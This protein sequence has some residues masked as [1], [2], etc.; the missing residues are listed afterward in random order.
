[1]PSYPIMDF[2]NWCILFTV[3]VQLIVI[4][5]WR[6]Q[7]IKPLKVLLYMVSHDFIPSKQVSLMMY[8]RIWTSHT[9]T[10]SRLHMYTEQ[11]AHVHRASCTCTQGSL[12]MYTEQAAHVHR[13]GCRKSIV[14]IQTIASLWST[15]G[16]FKT[17]IPSANGV[18]PKL[19]YT[20]WFPCSE[21]CILMGTHQ[22]CC[23]T[24][25][26]GIFLNP[27]HFQDGCNL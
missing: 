26:A 15:W 16:A 6:Y 23:C 4:Q 17:P 25:A 7:N 12:H 13:A 19:T 21:L 2:K 10:Q 3:V 22:I 20:T 11:A 18:Q 24:W 1:M 9:Y 14:V 5:L 27:A 8:I